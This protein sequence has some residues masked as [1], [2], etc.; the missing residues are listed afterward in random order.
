MTTNDKLMALLKQNG[1]ACS[2][3][4]INTNG[5][6]VNVAA[7]MVEMTKSALAGM[8]LKNIRTVPSFENFICIASHV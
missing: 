4:T 2:Y 7:E 1:I 5:V 6:A 8:G 3:A